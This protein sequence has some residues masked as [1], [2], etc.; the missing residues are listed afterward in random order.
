MIILLKHVVLEIECLFLKLNPPNFFKLKRILIVN[1]EKTMEL[2][3]KYKCFS[4]IVKFKIILY[5]KKKLF[6]YM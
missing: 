1:S 3:I 5:T 6:F 4:S 2:F